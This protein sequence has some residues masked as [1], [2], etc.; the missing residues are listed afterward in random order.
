M[1]FKALSCVVHEQ[2]T[3]CLV[4]PVILKEQKPQLTDLGNR[5]DQLCNGLVRRILD[6]GDLHAQVGSTLLLPEASGISAERILLLQLGTLTP[7]SADF[8]KALDGAGKALEPLHIHDVLFALAEISVTEQDLAWQARQLA[9][10]ISSATYRF[11]R[12]KSLA[13]PIEHAP[14]EIVHLHLAEQAQQADAGRG[15]LQG[16]AIASG[17]A[18]ARDL[19]NLPGNICTP[20]YQAEQARQLTKQSSQLSVEV[21]GE[22]QMEALGMGAFLSVAKGSNQ[23]GQLIAMHYQGAAKGD[24][25]YVLVGKGITFDS[26][27]ISLKPGA[28]MDEMKFDMCGAASVLGVMTALVRLQLPINVVGLIAAAENMPAGHASKPGDIVTSMSGQTVEILNTDAE[29]RLVLCDTLTYAERFEP[30]AVIDIATLTGACIIALGHQVSAVL[31]N[32]DDLVQQLL[33]SGQRAGDKAWQLPLFDEY[34]SQLDSNFADMANIGGRP[35]GTI[36]A[37]CFLSRFAKAYPWAHL[38][39]A[40]TAW[41][42]GKEKGATGRP[43]ALLLDYLINRS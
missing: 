7:S 31:G 1:E 30:A 8:I 35:A 19:G 43:V 18:S 34:Q 17:I 38:D 36:T 13:D 25:P 32:S 41:N 12:C 22:A 15:L 26:G 21:L 29:G 4:L 28:Q 6:R 33:Q 5:I 2:R 37:A 23:E 10:R 16:S 20:G 9:E 39:I 24:K 27:G 42:S 3:D 14:L 40:G 11:T